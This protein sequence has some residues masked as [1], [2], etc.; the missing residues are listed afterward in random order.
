MK[1]VSRKKLFVLMVVLLTFSV[2][3]GILY[4]H[5]DR[6]YQGYDITVGFL[7]EPA[8][9]GFP[10]GAS[11]R[12]M[13]L[14][15]RAESSHEGHGSSHEG[16]GSSHEGHGSSHE[17]HGSS[18]EGHASSHQKLDVDPEEH[19][20]IFSSPT[21]N[22][23]DTFSFAITKDLEGMTIPFHNHLR[24]D[25]V[26]S[27]NVQK[28][29][30]I[31]GTIVIEINDS[32]LFEPLTS[33]ASPGTTIVWKNVGQSYAN[34]TSGLM[35]DTASTSEQIREGS[36]VL[37]L[38]ST[39]KVEITHAESGNVSD[40][41]ELRP[42]FNDPG[43]YVADFIPT[44]PGIY[45]FRFTGFIESTAFEESFESGT[46]GFDLVQSPSINQFPNKV[47]SG[48]EIEGVV[49]GLQSDYAK[50]GKT[51]ITLGIAGIV[52]GI[53]GLFT[54]SVSLYILISK[55]DR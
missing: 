10:N 3:S 22:P 25:V 44:H 46:G 47:A 35:P 2:A 24:H 15:D 48:R 51:Y 6:T 11:I 41:M 9:E 45:K 14:Q 20:V 27:I 4:A 26:G 43:H 29:F 7:E 18:H 40:L 33:N 53:L 37:G 5:E 23:E 39:L 32:G 52:C 50:Q 54:G 12:V 38:E 36:P 1:M 8:F 21:I 42:V 49:R 28:H 31:S 13:K 30:D 34:V 17:G 19:G 16:H 55:R